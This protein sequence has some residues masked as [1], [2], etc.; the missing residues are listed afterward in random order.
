MNSSKIKKI[1]LIFLGLFLAMGCEDDNPAG[2]STPES[3]SI[4]GTITFSGDFPATGTVSVS[5][6]SNWLPTGAPAKSSE[7]TS[8]SNGTYTYLFEN[9]S[10]GSYASLAVSWQDPDDSNS[11]TNQHVIG[12]HGG[13]SP[14]MEQYGQGT[15]P[16]TITVSE[17]EF[18]LNID[19]TADFSL[20]ASSTGG[21]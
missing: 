10:F 16:T 17:T 4:Y 8:L 9:L 2:A 19:F 13:T 1:I 20:A 18:A 12:A 6:Q 15:D 3:A 11:Q 7:I 14:W 21:I 5:L